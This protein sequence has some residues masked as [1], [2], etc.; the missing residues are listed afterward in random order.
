[1]GADS[2]VRRSA[3]AA[4]NG[5]GAPDAEGIIRKTVDDASSDLIAHRRRLKGAH[6]LCPWFVKDR[7]R[8]LGRH[9]GGCGEAA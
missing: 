3:P 4:F 8:G 5:A 7:P 1:M 9:P 2:N 6:F